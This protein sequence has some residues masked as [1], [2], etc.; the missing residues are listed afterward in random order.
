MDYAALI[1]MLM[2]Q[3]GGLAGF[4]TNQAAQA[5]ARRIL[6]EARAEF[7]D[8]AERI[9]GVTDLEAAMAG[10]RLP[11]H[12][13]MEDI[14]PE[15]GALAQAQDESIA[16]LG[17]WSRPGMTDAERAMMSRA[18]GEIQRRNAADRAAL[19]R[20]QGGIGSGQALAMGQAAQQARG[21]QES[22]IALQAQAQAQARAL[23]ALRDRYGFA[24]QRSSDEYG[25]AR[26]SAQA[27]DAL[28][29][30]NAR[31]ALDK[32]GRIA[33]LR[34][35]RFTNDYNVTRGK[36]GMAGDMG[37]FALQGGRATA[38]AQA[39]GA[40]AFGRG[41]YSWLDDDEDGYGRG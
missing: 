35:Q 28:A 5:E 24:R 19:V 33:D 25:R 17:E 31:F 3:A 10:A 34:Q 18:F 13:A 14:A 2:S 9:P 6:E 30:A 21:Q 7:G 39:G 20:S 37:N 16:Q 32:A 36:A 4:A 27:K 29:A 15:R 26:D 1:S 22:D 38:G 23:S 40:A 41:L 12:S 8:L 11:T